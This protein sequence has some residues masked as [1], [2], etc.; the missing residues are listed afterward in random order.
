LELLDE[1]SKVFGVK[2][3]GIKLGL[4]NTYLDMY[5]SNPDAVLV[6]M[7]EQLNQ[8]GI[9]FIDNKEGA[10]DGA[11]SIRDVPNP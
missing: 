10:R 7:I 3:V 1:I 5:D 8:R 11:V 4:I 9:A 2:R 6:Y